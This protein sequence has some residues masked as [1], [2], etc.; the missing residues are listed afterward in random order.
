LQT[1]LAAVKAEWSRVVTEKQKSLDALATDLQA[2]RAK[3]AE[4][5]ARE[6]GHL[7]GM[8]QSLFN[9]LLIYI[10]IFKSHI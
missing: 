5:L 8:R 4:G 2:A 7:A 1:E 3:E 9:Y 6:H 10:L